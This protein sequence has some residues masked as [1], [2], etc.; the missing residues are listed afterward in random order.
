[1]NGENVLIQFKQEFIGYSSESLEEFIELPQD[2]Q[3][4]KWLTSAT[5]ED[6]ING[7]NLSLIYRIP[8]VQLAK[9]P[10][11]KIIALLKNKSEIQRV[12]IEN[13]HT[14]HYLPNDPLYGDQ[15][16]L[17]QINLQQALDL[18]NFPNGDIP[19]SE[20]ILLV[21]VDTGVDWTHSDLV[22]NIW[23]NLDED[24]D[25]DGQTIECDGILNNNICNG[26]WV[27][28]PD[29][30]NGID[31][32][33]WDADP[34]T[35]ID[36]LIGW[37]FVGNAGTA[38]NNPKPNLSEEY[39]NGWN[40]GTHV[41]GLLSAITDNNIGISSSAF[42]GKIMPLK[43]AMEDDGQNLTIINGFDAMLYAAKK[44]YYLNLQ[45]II[46]ASWGGN[47]FSQF[48]LETV[49]LIRENYKA[50]IVS[51][52]GNGYNNYQ[53]SGM[54]FP[55]SY[56]PVISVTPL[57]LNDN[58]NHW[59]H[60]HNTVDISAPGEGIL[61]TAYNN[62]Y[63]IFTGSSQASPIVASGIALLSAYHPEYN[64]E[65]LIRMILETS[66]SS[67]YNINEEEYIQGSLGKGRIDLETALVTPLFPSFTI[68]VNS[69][70]VINDIDGLASAGDTV[71][72]TLS[73][74]NSDNW[75]SA[76]S[77]FI[78][79]YILNSNIQLL[80]NETL[81]PFIDSGQSIPMDD[82]ILTVIFSPELSSGNYN[83]YLSIDANQHLPG[84]S[85]HT[86]ISIPLFIYNIIYYGDVNND[87]IVDILDVLITQGIIFGSLSE[88]HYS[89]SNVN[90]NFD[91][92]LNII[93]IVLIV[94]KILTD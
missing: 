28:D 20:N 66:D 10:I 68:I 7:S 85:Y 34:T 73:L 59:A 71:Q 52:A 54:I 90:L 78:S 65:Q 92:T 43:C 8:N 44:G 88:S 94:N 49:S 58:W 56:D 86:E 1:M 51:S 36:D 93:D 17:D 16:Y 63:S 50:I 13:I 19:N 83:L 62:Q 76:D 39:Y 57:G 38:D 55:A 75:G 22:Q 18:W 33:N 64:S 87:Q 30:L 61:S 53:V 82:N 72:I 74:H 2:L 32:D 80:G 4:V 14:I 48:E 84:F 46:N 6:I 12:E 21:A 27:L 79:P 81:I 3:L 35:L 23:Q 42:N 29:D 37:D 47:I 24:A 60:F 67:I 11:H 70:Q 26:E 9:I 40:H 91:D 77:I 5:N 31:D 15:W 25:N 69:M 45:T 89:V 41:A